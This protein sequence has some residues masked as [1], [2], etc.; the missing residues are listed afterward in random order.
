MGNCYI[1]AASAALNITIQKTNA[2]LLI[3]ADGGYKTAVENGFS[4]DIVLGDFD[5]LGFVPKGDNVVCLPVQ[6][7]DTDTLAA[8][9]IG[10]LKGYKTFYIYGGLGGRID[11]TIANIQTLSFITENGGKGFLV[12]ENEMVTL[13]KDT[14]LML[15]SQNTGTVSV[16]AYGGN[17]TGVSIKGLRYEISDAEL[18][19]SFP[20]GVSNELCGKQASISVNKGSLLIVMPK[21]II[22]E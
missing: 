9:R 6:K 12:G 10:L 8:V 3:A 1:I 4:P 16:F 21:E 22:L 18:N 5:S 2:D 7:D 11:H 14:A 13:I 17:A 15:K 20:I 19:A